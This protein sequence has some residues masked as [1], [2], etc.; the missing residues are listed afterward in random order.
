MSST[1][2]DYIVPTRYV[3]N[4]LFV[5]FFGLFALPYFFGLRL[6]TLGL[7]TNFLLLDYFYYK[8]LQKRIEIENQNNKWKDDE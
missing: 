1:W 5:I 2:L 8:L 3:K 6:T 4:Y 7:F